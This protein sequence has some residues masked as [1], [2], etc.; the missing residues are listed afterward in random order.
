MFDDAG[1]APDR[2]VRLHKLFT[3]HIV[4]PA[5]EATVNEWAAEARRE[6]RDRYGQQE[7]DRRIEIAREFVKNRPALA[8]LLTETGVGSH[9]DFIRALIASPHTLRINPRAEGKKG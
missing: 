5:D 7:A 6:A 4:E 1:I 3:R 2:A 8:Q 9:P